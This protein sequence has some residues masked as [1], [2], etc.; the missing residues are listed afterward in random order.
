MPAYLKLS[1]FSRSM[2]IV[3]KAVTDGVT[4]L[5]VDEETEDVLIP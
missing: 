5:I 1:A 3:V 4:V 2:T